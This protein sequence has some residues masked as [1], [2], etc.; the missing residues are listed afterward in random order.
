MEFQIGI[1]AAASLFTIITSSKNKH[2]DELADSQIGELPS[3]PKPVRADIF[4][5]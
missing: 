4:I 1:L 3:S 2:F 5:E